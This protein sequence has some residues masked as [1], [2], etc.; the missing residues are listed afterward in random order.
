MASTDSPAVARW[1]KGYKKVKILYRFLNL[2]K[3]LEKK[4]ENKDYTVFPANSYVWIPHEELC[5]APAKVVNSF[6]K[7]AVGEVVLIDE[8]GDEDLDETVVISAEESRNLLRMD[9]ESLISIP[10]MVSLKDLSNAS[11]LHNLRRRFSNDE[12]YTNVGSILVSVNPFKDLDICKSDYVLK[13]YMHS[14]SENR[15]HIYS[16]AKQAY[17]CLSEKSQS[18]IVSGESGAGKTEAT[19]I[20][21][22]FVNQS[23][24]NSLGDEPNVESKSSSEAS[25][26]SK[27]D[28]SNPVLEA[29]G[30][31]QTMRN[32]NSSRFGKWIKVEF[33]SVPNGHRAIVGGSVTNYLLEKSRVVDQTEGE[34]NYHIFYQLLGACQGQDEE[35]ITLAEKYKLVDYAAD[36]NEDE[37]G[38]EYMM[39]GIQEHDFED[40]N[41]LLKSFDI[42]GV[43]E[44]EKDDLFSLI[45]AIIFI[46]EIHF[47][48]D[49]KD[50]AT[51][52]EA[53]ATIIDS[54][55]ELLGIS[56]DLLEKTLTMRSIKLPKE[57][58]PILK[59]RN[60]VEANDIKHVLAKDLYSKIFD[61]LV[62]IVN[63]SLKPKR[64][65][66]KN[67]NFIGVLDIFGFESFAINSFEQ[68]CINYC[69]EKLQYHFNNHIFE[70][71]RLEYDV[72]NIDV[73]V[74]EF[75]N[76][77]K[78]LELL[79][80]GK[81]Q[82]IFSI[83]DA[84]NQLKYA[85]DEVLLKKLN[86]EHKDH[87][88]FE[89]SGIK[90]PMEF[91][92]NHY[93]GGVRYL[94]KEF[95]RK[96]EDQVHEDI[97]TA[98]ATSNNKLCQKL[99]VKKGSGK[100]LENKTQGGNKKKT[101][102][103]KFKDQ[104]AELMTTLQMTHPHFVRCIKPN[105]DKVDGDFDSQLV[106]DQ[107]NYAGLLEVC[108][109]RKVGY[110]IRKSCDEFW[111]R[112]KSIAPGAQVH[113]FINFANIH[114]IDMSQSGAVNFDPIS[115]FL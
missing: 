43:T 64:P 92:V 76:N 30:N 13:E 23:S 46:G 103:A 22:R 44:K 96:N 9:E 65:I 72:F 88:Y 16:L 40:W 115:C 81:G 34:R 10:D 70:V 108:R 83:I 48:A 41:K 14:L 89:P 38:L 6:E 11:I 47:D 58:E 18:C 93:A 102:G 75:K 68:L 60:V 87:D 55:C 66:K 12:I 109:I 33:E 20:F 54:A 105:N 113:S 50:E 62:T 39:G 24:L 3:F 106:L 35:S 99:F 69:N 19:K 73:S 82:G 91:T 4:N 97:T 94:I 114:S 25:L 107:L 61:H 112:Y 90:T 42:L 59:P 5:Y 32:N 80:L 110:P 67:S 27:I 31:A 15:P 57:K 37:T 36:A 7:G 49:A 29:F 74:I 8:P 28:S 86:L 100:S 78:C 101:I 52:K 45:S 77:D 71:E 84:H 63:R 17:T 111:K 98:L 79:E 21:L 56:K 85:T 26:Q 95:L 51:L 104:L 1:R 53:E 2:G